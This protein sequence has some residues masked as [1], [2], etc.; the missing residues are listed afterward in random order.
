VPCLFLTLLNEV[1][2]WFSK[3][4]FVLPFTKQYFHLRDLQRSGQSPQFG[5]FK[6]SA[7]DLY[8]KGILLSIDQQS[9]R[10]FDRINIVLSSNKVGI[11]TVD[12]Y[13]TDAGGSSA[14]ASTDIR[15]DDLLQA[16]FENKVSLALFNGMAKFNV[17]L[18]LYQLNK[19]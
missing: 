19:K 6:Y 18:L 1:D 8:D 15:L 5:S 2:L 16:Q 11:F 17:N 3:K 4:R 9:P 7:Q 14:V 10:Q 12:L 13:N